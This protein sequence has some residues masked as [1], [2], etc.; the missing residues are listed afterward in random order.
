MTQQRADCRRCG[1]PAPGATICRNCTQ[2]LRTNLA[3]VPDVAADLTITYARKDKL[4]D[5][6]LGVITRHTDPGLS[7][8]QRASAAL[9][10]L[11]AVLAAEM[12]RLA[13]TH[14]LPAPDDT[15]DAMAAWL[16]HRIDAI[17]V[18]DQAPATVDTLDH[19]VA[20]A[21]R[22]IDR[23]PARHYLGPCDQCGTDLYARP[24]ADVV[25]CV[26]CHQDYNVSRRRDWLL[27]AAENALATPV[28]LSHAL[29]QLL[30]HAPAVGTIRSWISRGRLTPHSYLGRSPLVRVG[31]VINLVTTQ[32]R[33]AG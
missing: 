23:P 28:E 29:P 33:K 19:A 31:D 11:H 8:N 21:R 13:S 18:D 27:A 12:A 20:R 4:G 3:A 26:S 1:A 22:V 25:V 10:H 2:L 15:V 24:G 16:A 32:P 9:N 14:A 5:G 30:D 6:R 7:F 17:R